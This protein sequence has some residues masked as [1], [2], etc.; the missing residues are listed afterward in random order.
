MRKIYFLILIILIV[1]GAFILWPK[2]GNAPA[3]DS[4]S[5]VCTMEAKICPD[6]S[7]VGRAGPKC[8]FAKCP[9]VSPLP[10]LS[11]TVKGSVKLSPVCPVERMPP[12]PACA[13]KPYQTKIEVFLADGT[14]LVKTVESDSNGNFSFALPYGD[15]N[16]QAGSGKVYPRCEAILVSLKTATPP[17][18]SI[19]CDTGIR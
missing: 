3:K 5:V 2:I 10:T 12:D 17:L 7:A 15:Y 13:P 19:S 9:E 11:A 4:G 14:E 1:G 6:G 8:E 16:V 18:I